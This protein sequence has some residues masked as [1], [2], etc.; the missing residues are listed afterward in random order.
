[1]RDMDIPEGPIYKRSYRRAESGDGVL[2]EGTA[3]PST[4]IR[5]FAEAL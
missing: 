3:S 4:P 2:G 5:G 1:L